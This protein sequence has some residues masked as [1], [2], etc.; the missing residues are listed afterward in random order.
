MGG[1][2]GDGE[3][4]GEN[5]ANYLGR[6]EEETETRGEYEFVPGLGVQPLPSVSVTVHLLPGLNILQ[7]SPGGSGS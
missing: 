7:M 2:R 1:V 4:I 5:S 6:H 3:G